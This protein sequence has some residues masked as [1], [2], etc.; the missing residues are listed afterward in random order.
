MGP[1][2]NDANTVKV[3]LDDRSEGLEAHWENDERHEQDDGSQHRIHLS[4]MATSFTRMPVPDMNDRT[5][6][7][8]GTY[9]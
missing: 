4:L 6:S 7:K 3:V 5:T 1:N 2:L 9:E 8:Y